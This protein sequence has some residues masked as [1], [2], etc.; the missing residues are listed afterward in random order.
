MQ[1][2]FLILSV[3]LIVIGGLILQSGST[4]YSR[5]AIIGTLVCLTANQL[6]I[7]SRS[8]SILKD[9]FDTILVV[10]FNCLI[11]YGLYRAVIT[12]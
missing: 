6:F 4:D 12:F 2:F 11:I 1:L 7:L 10:I 5:M 9:R 3:V 8:I